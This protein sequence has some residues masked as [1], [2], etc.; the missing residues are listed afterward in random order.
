MH[1]DEKFK[2]YKKEKLEISAAIMKI[3]YLKKK[4]EFNIF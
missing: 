4:Y 1:K 2:I 3:Y